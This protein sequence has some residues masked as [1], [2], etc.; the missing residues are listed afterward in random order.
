MSWKGI[1]VSLIKS[2]VSRFACRYLF[3]VDAA[4]LPPAHRKLIYQ[5]DICKHSIGTQ[6]GG[7]RIQAEIE[8]II[9]SSNLLLH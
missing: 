9:F 2:P 8:T 1:P 6:T 5:I 4:W 7:M 3:P